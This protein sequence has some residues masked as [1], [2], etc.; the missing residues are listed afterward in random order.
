MT[1]YR[2]NF[3]AHASTSV[4]VEADNEEEAIELAYDTDLPYFPGGYWNVDL[5]EWELPSNFDPKNNYPEDDVQV[6]ED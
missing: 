4:V 6:E 5:S 1:K 3:Y 2:V